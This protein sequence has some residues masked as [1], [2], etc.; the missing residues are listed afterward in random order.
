VSRFHSLIFLSSFLATLGCSA[1]PVAGPDK[2][3]SGML[4]GV[5]TGAGSGA[6]VGAQLA[7]GAGPGAA[8]GAGFGAV[9]GALKGAGID[10]L[11]EEDIKQLEEIEKLKL[12]VAAQETLAE[13]YKARLRLYPNREIYPADLFFQGD[14]KTLSPK[15]KM[16]A[17]EIA[18]RL[19][20][21]MPWS[22]IKIVSYLSAAGGDSAFAERQ[23]Y[24]RAEQIAIQF[25]RGGIEPR[26]LSI[27]SATIDAPL[28]IDPEDHPARYRQA[29]EV[30][31]LDY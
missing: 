18:K 12:T 19:R 25:I 24:Q 13:H 21:D 11:E 23:N 17:R 29:I 9:F 27:Q 30:V 2:Q 1:G 22:R 7:A 8:V 4:A 15:T 6:V 20:N 14:E 3:G 10:M 31:P 28:V 16:L 26:R 5:V